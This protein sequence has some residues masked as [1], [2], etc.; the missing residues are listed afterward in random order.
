M[1]RIYHT[2]DKWECYPAGFYNQRHPIADTSNQVAERQYADFLKNSVDF[3]AALIRVLKEWKNSC[4]HY[5]SNENMNRIAW[6]GQA[7]ACIAKK[8][9]S[10]FRGGFNMLTEAE[11]ETANLLALKYLNLWLV[12]N[13]GEEIASLEDAQSKTVANLY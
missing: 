5:L 8:L 9:P 12:A 13:G 6:L 11:K 10:C 1:N 7:S 2:W 4:E 3:E